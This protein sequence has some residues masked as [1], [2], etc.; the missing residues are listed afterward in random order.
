MR[1]ADKLYRAP[2]AILVLIFCTS[3][4]FL[5]Y[6]PGLNGSFLLD[7]R[8]N[9]EVN[10]DIKIND[11]SLGSLSAAW[12]AGKTGGLGRPISALSFALT[13]FFMDG[14]A[15]SYKITNVVLHMVNMLLVMGFVIALLR[16]WRDTH[17]LILSGRQIILL[18]GVIGFLWA[19]HPLQVSTVLYAVQR[20]AILSSL[21]TV[22]ALWL[23]ITWRTRLAKKGIFRWVAPVFLIILVALGVLSKESAIL[24]FGFIGLLEFF[25][26]RQLRLHAVDRLFSTAFWTAAIAAIVVAIAYLHFVENWYAGSYQARDFDLS[27]RLMTQSRV[28]F[29]YL[30]WILFPSIDQYGLFHD[31]IVTSRGLVSPAT[32]LLSLIGLFSLTFIAVVVR[33]TSPWLGYGIGFYLVGHVLEGSFIPLELVFEHRNYLP[34]LGVLII[35]V[36]GVFKLFQLLNVRARVV[37]AIVIA[38]MMFYASMSYLRALEWSSYS[39]QLAAAVERHPNSARTHWAMGIWYL[40][41][42]SEE[43]SIGLDIP[44]RYR[45]GKYYALKAADIDKAYVSSYL[46]LILFHYQNNRP[47]PEQWLHAVGDRLSTAIYRAETDD[48]FR[49]LVKCFRI[50]GCFASKQQIDY[51]FE[52]ALSNRSLTDHTRSNLLSRYST[53]LYHGGDLSASTKLLRQAM[54]FAPSVIG[55]RNLTVLALE[56]NDRENAASYFKELQTQLGSDELEEMQRLETLVFE[57]CDALLPEKKE[58]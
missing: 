16:F 13:Q 50:T 36:I 7:D 14:S 3:M 4:I 33:R 10:E 6:Q 57:C 58:D 34:S 41:T 1:C 48:Y 51:L 20:M 47:F 45:D 24:F 8:H 56:M 11:L 40:E 30:Q 46:G 25:S 21:F 43:L 19:L 22:A 38:V 2:V 27:E 15:Y 42:H 5:I 9:I 37:A 12:S 49:Q 17:Q 31:D 18:G 53:L 35:L 39:G 52:R 55:Y 28:I 44:Q 26:Y 23:Y 29:M 32:T 54:G